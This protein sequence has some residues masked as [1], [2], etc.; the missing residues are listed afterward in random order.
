MGRS[1]AASPIPHAS[2]AGIQHLTLN[3]FNGLV[4]LSFIIRK[5]EVITQHKKRPI[6]QVCL[7]Q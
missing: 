2:L 6:E 7:F 5:E 3:N 1:D 4:Y